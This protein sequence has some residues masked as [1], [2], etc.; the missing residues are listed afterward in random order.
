ML[1]VADTGIGM[2][3]EVRRRCLEPFF[4]T[5]DH[6]P[7][8]GMGLSVVYGIVQR[9]EGTLE[10]LTRAG[11]GTTV[12]IRLPVHGGG[13]SRGCALRPRSAAGPAAA[14]AAGRGRSAWCARW[15]ASICGATSTRFRRR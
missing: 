8:T 13:G 7:G 10:I 2:T 5:K 12:R 15:S 6:A 14:G 1:E 9:H 11:D 3:D 4:T